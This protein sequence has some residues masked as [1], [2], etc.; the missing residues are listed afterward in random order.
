MSFFHNPYHSSQQFAARQQSGSS[1]NTNNMSP[2]NTPG[3]SAQRTNPYYQSRAYH[4]SSGSNPYPSGP[5]PYPSGSNHRPSISNPYPHQPSHYPRGS[6]SS[7]TFPANNNYTTPT[8][9]SQQLTTP[10]RPQRGP[11]SRDWRPQDIPARSDLERILSEETAFASAHIVAR[12]DYVLANLKHERNPDQ[13]RLGLEVIERL[14]RDDL[15]DCNA[16][17]EAFRRELVERD[18]AV[19]HYEREFR[20]D[21]ERESRR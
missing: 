15:T 19:A 18:R 10:P 12:I 11:P 13:I 20:E 7:F 21:V 3:T 2:N 16:K 1:N 4:D 9:P 14:R 8:R 6:N 17:I 5:I